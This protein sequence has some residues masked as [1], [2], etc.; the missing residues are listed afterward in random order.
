MY[1]SGQ[2]G[3]PYTYNFG[4]DVNGDGASTERPAVLSAA[5]QVTSHAGSTYQDLVNFLEAATATA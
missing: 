2:T 1:Y 4:V 3:R 5:D